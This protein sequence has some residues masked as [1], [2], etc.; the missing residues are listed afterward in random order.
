[1]LLGVSVP[2]SMTFSIICSIEKAFENK[3]DFCHPF[4]MTFSIVCLIEK[5]VENAIK[6]LLDK[7][8]V[9]IYLY[10]NR[11]TVDSEVKV[12]VHPQRVP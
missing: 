12:I 3:A 7:Q 8:A 6:K 9:K 4:S 1:M 5:A 11:K 10:R 2:F